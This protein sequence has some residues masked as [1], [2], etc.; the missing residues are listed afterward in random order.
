MSEIHR[1][2]SV[3]AIFASPYYACCKERVER[4]HAILKSML[5]KLCVEQPHDW[6]R[7]IPLGLFPYCEIRND[8]LKLS[9]FELLYGRKVC[10]PLTVLHELSKNKKLYHYVKS[11]YQYVLELR[12]RFEESAL[13]ASA[14]AKI[15]KHILTTALKRERLR[16]AMK[17]WSCFPPPITS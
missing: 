12:T 2:L 16:K 14:H 7:Y 15:N 4:F 1:S 10:R 13:L 9:P 8:S 3:K 6:D 11:L 17:L 5:K